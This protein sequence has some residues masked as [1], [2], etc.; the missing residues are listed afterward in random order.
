MC[1]RQRQSRHRHHGLIPRSD[2]KRGARHEHRKK[3]EK[4]ASMKRGMANGKKP[5]SQAT[6]MPTDWA[7]MGVEPYRW[8]S[9]RA[10]RSWPSHANHVQLPS[11]SAC[12]CPAAIIRHARPEGPSDHPIHPITIITQPFPSHTHT[13]PAAVLLH[14]REKKTL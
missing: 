11:G 8:E 14:A 3:L 10:P 5:C 13:L 9:S 7:G 1:E 6:H 4:K 12:A 2:R